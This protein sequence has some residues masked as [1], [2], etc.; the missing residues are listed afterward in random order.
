MRLPSAK[1]LELI[2]SWL[3]EARAG[4]PGVLSAD[5]SGLMIYGDIGGAAYIRADGTIEIEAEIPSSAWS[6]NPN[7]LT[8]ILVCASKC[9][10]ALAELLPERPIL[11]EDCISCSASGWISVGAVTLVC[12]DCYGLG[13]V[14]LP[15]T[16]L[17]RTREG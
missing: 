11:A 3:S 12:G 2:R 9:R 10:P 8:S 14:S 13:W 17:E 7:M 16:S 6:T 15:N 4:G 5:G 1:L